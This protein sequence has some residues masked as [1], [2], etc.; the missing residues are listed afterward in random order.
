METQAAGRTASVDLYWLP[1]G[2]GDGTHLVGLSGRVYEHLAARHDGRE[3]RR[4]FHSALLVHTGEATYAVEMAP[5]WRT[6]HADR[7]VTGEGAVGLA[8]LGRSRL[9]RYEVRCWRDGCVPDLAEAVD[10]PQRLGTDEQRAT[11]LLAV[12]PDFP[13]R[14]WGRDEQGVGDMWNSNSLISW[15]LVSSGHE[16]AGLHPPHR[17]RAPGWDAGVAAASR[18][19]RRT[20]AAATTRRR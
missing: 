11:R 10:S 9:F 14:T 4:L 7:G 1:L 18:Q 17:G 20:A 15:V 16:V 13:C 3:P 2:A 12:I 6:P 8:C 5:V 19:R